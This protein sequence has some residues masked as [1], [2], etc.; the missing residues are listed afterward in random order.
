MKNLSLAFTIVTLFAFSGCKDK[1]TLTSSLQGSWELKS[2][3]NGWTGEVNH[4]SGN[5]SVLK[6]GQTTYEIYSGGKLLKSG[7]YKV[8]DAISF[9]TKLPG[10]KLVYDNEKDTVVTFIEIKDNILTLSIDAY[11]AGSSSYIKISDE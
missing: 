8:E 2:S 3:F 6:F 7:V 1:E 10:K 5:G 4:P 9:L 11:D